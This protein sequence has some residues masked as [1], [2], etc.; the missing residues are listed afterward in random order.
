VTQVL[1]FFWFLAG[2]GTYLFEII[3][4][5]IGINRLIVCLSCDFLLEGEQADGKDMGFG[6][7]IQPTKTLPSLFLLAFQPLMWSAL[8]VKTNIHDTKGNKR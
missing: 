8:R 2:I 3:W 5:L 4:G 6:G 1:R 7:E